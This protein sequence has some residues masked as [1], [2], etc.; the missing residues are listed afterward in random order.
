M[1]RPKRQTLRLRIRKAGQHLCPTRRPRQSPWDL[2]T[3]G[4]RQFANAIGTKAAS[5]DPKIYDRLADIL[6]R[7]NFA[8]EAIEYKQQ[9]VALD[10]SNHRRRWEY[11]QM[12]AVNERSADA[13]QQ[14]QKLIEL[15]DREQQTLT[16]QTKKKPIRR[17]RGTSIRQPFIPPPTFVYHS[18]RF[19]PQPI[20]FSGTPAYYPGMSIRYSSGRY[21]APPQ[22]AFQQLRSQALHFMATL[23][24]DSIGQDALIEQ[25]TKKIDDQPKST[26]AKRDLMLIYQACGRTED[27]IDLATGILE[28]APNDAELL[29]QIA[30]YHTSRQEHDKAI[31][32]YEKLAE[33]QSQYRDQALSSIISLYIQKQNHE[34]AVAL[35]NQMVEENPDNIHPLL[36][37]ANLTRQQGQLDE[38]IAIYEKARKKARNVSAVFLASLYKQKGDKDKA[39]KLYA[40]ILAGDPAQ[41]AAAAR[42]PQVSLYIPPRDNRVIRHYGGSL[43][44]ALPPTL[45]SSIDHQKAE[46]IRQLHLLS[47]EDDNPLQPLID[48]AKQLGSAKSRDAKNKAWDAAKLLIASCIAENQLDKAQHWLDEAKAAAGDQMEWINLAL[49][50]AQSRDDCGA[51]IELYNQAKRQFSFQARKIASAKAAVFILCKRY[52]EAAAH[53]RQMIQQRIPPKELVEAIR[54]L[55]NAGETQLAKELLKEHL[56]G[57]SRNV[58]ALTLLANIYSGEENYEQAIT[59]AHEAWDRSPAGSST[60]NY[61]R[62]SSYYAPPGRIRRP[63]NNL[64]R[65]LHR[66]YVKAGRSG[67]LIQEFAERLAKQPGSVRLHENLATLYSLNNQNNKAIEI[68]ETL[69]QKRPRLVQAKQQLAGFYAQTGNLAKASA[70]YEQLL[71]TNPNLYQQISRELQNFYR[72]HGQEKQ[73]LKFEENLARRA[74]NPNQIQQLASQFQGSGNLEKAAELYQKAIRLSPSHPWLHH[75]LA[76]VYRQL[77]RQDDAIKL[78]KDWLT[79]PAIHAQ[80]IGSHI[81]QP[82]TGLYASAGRLD[83]LKEINQ[84]LQEKNAKSPLANSLAIQIAIFEKRFDDA[85]ERLTKAVK[86]GQN[87]NAVNDLINIGQITGRM[88]E[89]L[90]NLPDSALQKNFSDK[91]RLAK[92]YMN[93]GNIDRGKKLY[94]D[95]LE[96]QAGHGVPMHY[97]IGEAIRAF[98]DHGLWDDIEALIRKH[99]P[100]DH[101]QR[102]GGPMPHGRQLYEINEVVAEAYVEHN[103]FKNFVQEILDKETHTAAEAEL[104]IAIAKQYEWSGTSKSQREAFLSQV[105]S[106]NPGNQKLVSELSQIYF[107][108]DQP[109]KAV[110]LA[111]QLFEAQPDNQSHRQF[112]ANA[113]LKN[114]Q[115]EKVVAL[116]RQ[117]IEA[118]PN[119]QSHRQLY[120]DALFAMKSEAQALAMLSSWAAV[121]ETESRYSFLS[122]Y[123]ER[124]GEHAAARASLVKAMALADASRKSD[125]ALQLAQFDAKRGN[126]EAVKEA[127][128]KLFKERADAQ[129]FQQY[130]SYLHNS[131]HEED[132]RKLFLKH[133]D[134]GYI[135]RYRFRNVFELFLDSENLDTLIDM[136]WKRLRYEESRRHSSIFYDVEI[137]FHNAFARRRSDKNSR[138]SRAEK[139]KQFLN[140]IRKRAEAEKPPNQKILRLLA[141]AYKRAGLEEAAGELYGELSQQNPANQEYALQRANWLAK[142]GQTDEAIQLIERLPPAPTLHEEADNQLLFIQFYLKNQKPKRAQTAINKLL[143][144]KG[145]GD[146]EIKIGNLF[147]EREQYQKA[148]AHYESGRNKYR[149]DR[150]LAGEYFIN[151]GKCYAVQ[152]QSAAAI[153]SFE[154]ARGKQNTE[155]LFSELSDWLMQKKLYSTAV[156]WLEA[157]LKTKTLDSESHLTLAYSYIHLNQPKKAIAAYQNLWDQSTTESDRE[158]IARGFESLILHHNLQEQLEQAAPHPLLQNAQN[159]ASTPSD[160]GDQISEGFFGIT[161]LGEL[162][163]EIPAEI[164]QNIEMSLEFLE[165]YNIRNNPP[166]IPP[167]PPAILRSITAKP[168]LAMPMTDADILQH[169]RENRG[170]LLAQPRQLEPLFKAASEETARQLTEEI[171][172]KIPDAPHQAYYRFLAAHFRKKSASA[173]K[174]LNALTKNPKLPP[175]QLKHLAAICRGEG[176]ADASIVFLNRLVGG[177]Y[178]ED[179]KWEALRELPGLQ[180]AVGDFAGAFSNFAKL[181]PRLHQTGRLLTQTI[182][183]ATDEQNLPLFRAAIATLIAEQPGRAQIPMLVG[184]YR[185]ICEKLGTTPK[186]FPLNP[187]QQEEAN[188]FSNLIQTWEIAGP[189]DDEPFSKPPT[190]PAAWTKKIQP[191]DTFGFIDFD[192]LFNTESRTGNETAALP[193]TVEFEFAEMFRTVAYARTTLISPDERSITL[194]FETDDPGKVWIND[195]EIRFMPPPIVQNHASASVS[196]KAGEN[197]LTVKVPNYPSNNRMSDAPSTWFFNIRI[198]ENADS[199]AI[200]PLDSTPQQKADTAPNP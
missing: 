64:L 200:Q 183:T 23:A 144:W 1:A 146:T 172:A 117:L 151:M 18:S 12:L 162:V 124:A 168:D 138:A 122:R 180:L 154:K 103:R 160:Q 83:E 118:E 184:L 50:L 194:A 54:P 136:A 106:R 174:E 15:G 14:L 6:Q 21:G 39:K 98:G 129:T 109:E 11:A 76:G 81:L 102:L 173:S 22:S 7:E 100:K 131:G 145:D 159:R 92:I 167:P 193:K 55:V 147:I 195:E 141:G 69:I 16:E 70:L 99:Y 96:E 110:A 158:D 24:Q 93:T 178:G 29:Q 75:Q 42:R 191:K 163:R 94:K 170:A 53:I 152:G 176:R 192:S 5:S 43:L 179:E 36:Q 186:P 185:E 73:I 80:S 67:E 33:T 165:R 90:K 51:L 38:A 84:S 188:Q 123:Q 47:D 10:E 127:Y 175:K 72:R 169:V 44:R 126:P 58:E 121:K 149:Q 181:P 164:R 37:L 135:N 48:Q 86:T 104:L 77:G 161:L 46:A 78:Y 116:A 56:S 57:I 113:L 105:A 197:R 157:D 189:Y 2:E 9:A 112:Y 63:A 27:A 28:L 79:S 128:A 187:T 45:I 34:K 91:R 3:N 139:Q 25:F 82:I 40:E 177:G 49:Y 62:Y 199:M 30:A 108:N 89:V 133:K 95:W 107:N 196:L 17:G 130:I 32:L 171:N 41:P 132:A 137:I 66:Y 190:D 68:Y 140:G 61:R 74:T 20:M 88:D 142:S 87:P 4:H 60:P 31:T 155:R 8:Q 26:Q 13:I 156:A 125:A 114:D 150:Y 166:A 153:E 97:Y 101:R 65:N 19:I 148:L 134:A 115:P 198:A 59:L 143:A 85:I 111:R 119:N 182:Y 35:A 52:N 120:A 71:Q